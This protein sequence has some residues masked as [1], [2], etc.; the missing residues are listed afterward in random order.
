MCP[1]S[2][3]LRSDGCVS[4]C[5]VTCPCRHGPCGSGGLATCYGVPAASK[6][7]HTGGMS[8]RWAEQVGFQGMQSRVGVGSWQ[9]AP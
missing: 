2:F 5:P 1:F 6:R 9:E 7:L 4:R 3:F 8:G